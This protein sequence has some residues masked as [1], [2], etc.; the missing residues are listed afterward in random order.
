M[1]IP[2]AL[3]GFFYLRLADSQVSQARDELRRRPLPAGLECRGRRDAHASQPRVRLPERRRSAPQGDVLAQQEEV[4]KQIAALDTIDADLGK[5]LGVSDAWQSVK[6]EWATVKAKALTAVRGR[7]RRRARGAHRSPPAARRNW[8]SVRSKTSLDPEVATH[9]L[10]RPGLRPHSEGVD[11]REQ[12]APLRREGRR[13]GLSRRRRPHGHADLPRSLPGARSTQP[14]GA[15]ERLPADA[16]AELRAAFDS[17]G[18]D[19]DEYDSVVQA[20]LLDAANLTATGAEHLRRRRPHE[21]RCQE[22]LRRQ[23]RRDRQGPASSA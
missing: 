11:L 16:R 18:V 19:V 14:H 22:A 21:P 10:I 23:L 7:E 2:A 20:K 6:S 5:R 15:L 17:R 3:V 4:E 1:A 13:Q 12:H 8:S 9:A